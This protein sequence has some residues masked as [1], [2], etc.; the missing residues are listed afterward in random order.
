MENDMSDR[1]LPFSGKR[2][3][4]LGALQEPIDKPLGP[5]FATLLS[6]YDGQERQKAEAIVGELVDRGCI[7]FCCVGPEAEELH[8]SID[9]IIED[10]EAFSVVTTWH[11]N[12][13]E[14][15]EYFVSAAAGKPCV[16]LAL[17]ATHPE[18]VAVLEQLVRDE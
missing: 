7:E 15:C 9:W 1:T 3:L 11:E 12:Q 13:M 17:V 2:I 4:V 18:V 6:A 14:A 16:L 10:K 5:R 8:D